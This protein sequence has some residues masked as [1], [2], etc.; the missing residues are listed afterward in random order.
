[1]KKTAGMQ[2]FRHG[3]H[4][5]LSVMTL[6]GVL[7]AEDAL[8]ETR[9]ALERW[10]QTR[11]LI[12]KTRADWQ[13]DKE[14]LEQ[15]AALYERELKS[16]DEAMGKVAT[17]HTQVAK[18]MAEAEASKT[19][20]DAA[21]ERARQTITELESAVKQLV[22]RLPAPLQDL[23]RKDLGRLPADPSATRMLAAERV[24][25]VVGL[26]NEFD[27]F[28]NAVNVFS[29][30]RRNPRGEEVAVQ[31]LYVGL[32]AAY[33]VNDTAD[34]AGVG[35]PGKEGWQWTVRPELAPAIQDAIK[36]YRS[37]RPARFVT[38]PVTIQ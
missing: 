3:A 27:K 37:E 34:F 18:E 6:S 23:T 7:Q 8:N 16:L 10:M 36:I 38:L 21:L 22:P 35:A 2:W 20:S 11:Q 19:A 13:G 32:G 28:N 30:K 15:T 26:L 25:V 1:M 9:S 17:N 29:E 14:L 5:I 12:A 33:F 24:Q 4:L 31:T